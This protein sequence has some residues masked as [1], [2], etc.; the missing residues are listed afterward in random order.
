MGCVLAAVLLV[1]GRLSAWQE[2]GLMAAFFLIIAAIQI[3][4]VIHDRNRLIH[5]LEKALI[6]PMKKK[7]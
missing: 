6:Q 3:V 7:V 5:E 4:Q 2:A 1:I